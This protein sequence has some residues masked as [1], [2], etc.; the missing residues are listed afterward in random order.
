M[1]LS[2]SARNDFIYV[3]INDSKALA[4]T[5]HFIYVFVFPQGSLAE[6]RVYSL[7]LFAVVS[8]LKRENYTVPRRGLSHK[9][10]MDPRI[11]LNYL[12]GSF[13]APIM[14]QSTV[15]DDYITI[16]LLLYSRNEQQG[17]T[18]TLFKIHRLEFSQMFTVK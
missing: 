11:C 5:D 10:H 9:L 13:T 14:A 16:L 1:R 15:R 12:P 7:G 4:K 18:D 2:L 3:F 6:V 8:C 17:E